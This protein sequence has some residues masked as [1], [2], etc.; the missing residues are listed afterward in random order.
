MIFRLLLMIYLLFIM[1][2]ISIIFILY[3]TFSTPISSVERDWDYLI[4]SLAWPPTYC[5]THSCKLPYKMNDF[6]IHGLW[7]SKW[8]RGNPN[9]PT[10]QPF[11]VETIQPIY[12]ELQKQWANLDDFDKPEA[13]WQHEWSKHGVCAI[14]DAPYISNEFDYFNMSLVIKSKVNLM[15]RLESVKITPNN[16]VTL[17]RDILLD[18][19]KSLFNV[20]VIIYC[21]LKHRTPAKLAEIRLCMNPSMEFINCPALNYTR[22]Q[23]HAQQLSLLSSNNNYPKFLFHN[24]LCKNELLQWF[25]QSPNCLNHPTNANPV[26]LLSSNNAPCPKELIFPDFDLINN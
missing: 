19:L 8:P 15:K 20:D 14:S 4:Y 10:D 18:Q 24:Y 7:P 6:N 16:M 2:H 17:K 1:L 13:F 23:Q 21:Y 5:Y 25:F 12:N 22:L 9:C 3:S 11:Q 26:L